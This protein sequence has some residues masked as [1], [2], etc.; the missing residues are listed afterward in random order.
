MSLMLLLQILG[1][2]GQNPS[3]FCLM[4][5][6]IFDAI[7]LP[8]VSSLE[9]EDGPP[10]KRRTSSQ[11]PSAPRPPQLTRIVCRFN[12]LLYGLSIPRACL[13]VQEVYSFQLD[14]IVF[15]YLQ[16]NNLRSPITL[17]LYSPNRWLQRVRLQ[18]MT[19]LRMNLLWSFLHMRE[20][21][22]QIFLYWYYC[23][24]FRLP[25]IRGGSI[26]SG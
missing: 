6:R 26:N 11:E 15:I 14:G 25:L 9:D 22:D 8:S 2:E 12:T 17:V 24:H 23:T 7:P 20:K 19:T 4:A 18:P 1:V 16:R 10:A 5:T 21:S 13:V 3:G